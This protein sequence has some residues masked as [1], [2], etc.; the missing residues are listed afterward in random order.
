MNDGEQDVHELTDIDSAK[1]RFWLG[2]PDIIILDNE[3]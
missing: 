3:P 2:R 1:T